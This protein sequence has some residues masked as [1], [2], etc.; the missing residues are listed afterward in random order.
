MPVPVPEPAA[1]TIAYVPLLEIAWAA[2]QLLTLSLPP[3]LL[4]T[5]WGARLRALCDRIARGNRFATLALFAALFL[6]LAALV[7][8]PIHY[9][10]DFVIGQPPGASGQ[11]VADPSLPAWIIGE[12][13]PLFAKTLAAALFLWIPYWLIR[14]F[15]RWWW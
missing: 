9:W 13:V 12:V 4:F 6:L 8:A 14:R 11:S 2:S 10:R 15:P 3:V 5:G 1:S 7:V